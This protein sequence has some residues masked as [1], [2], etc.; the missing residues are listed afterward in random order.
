M[1]GGSRRGVRRLRLRA[2]RRRSAG[3]MPEAGRWR[4][5]FGPSSGT[6]SRTGTNS[7]NGGVERAGRRR[8]TA[9]SSEPEMRCASA[10][11]VFLVAAGCA[12]YPALTAESPAPVALLDLAP[13]GAR[14]E[15]VVL[16][17]IDG[18]R[19]DAIE[20]AGAE[21]LKGLI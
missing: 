2:G 9:A 8:S 20:A 13:E 7:S 10:L 21:T 3:T 11:A 17:S 14:A 5:S 19:P 16:V 12:E 1:P 4:S 15:R 6:S 18:L